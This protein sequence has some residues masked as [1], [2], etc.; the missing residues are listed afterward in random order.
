M[1]S[2]TY[3]CSLAVKDMGSQLR[4]MKKI[5]Q[6]TRV[7]SRTRNLLVKTGK[8]LF[9][10]LKRVKNVPTVSKFEDLF[11]DEPEITLELDEQTRKF[12]W[13]RAR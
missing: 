2:L 8:T 10:I 6:L 3:F 12:P 13:E 11:G 9:K 4:R 5:Y 1:K 7:D